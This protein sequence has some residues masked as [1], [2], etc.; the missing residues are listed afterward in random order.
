GSHMRLLTP[1]LTCTSLNIPKLP[2]LKS[3]NMS[4]KSNIAKLPESCWSVLLTNKS[5]IKIK[6]GE[7]GYYPSIP[8]SY[9]IKFSAGVKYNSLSGDNGVSVDQVTTDQ[10]AD[11]LNSTEGITKGQRMA[12][13]WGSQFGWE[14]TL[15]DPDSYFENGEPK[16]IRPLAV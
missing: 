1:I 12:M 11:Y 13:D 8:P 4:A 16:E 9:S 3:K 10:I 6:A 14:S 15:A 5:L 7:T 2:K